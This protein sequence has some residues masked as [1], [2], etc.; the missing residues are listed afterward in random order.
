MEV[1]IYIEDL[2][3]LPAEVDLFGLTTEVVVGGVGGIGRF[4]DLL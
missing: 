2:F 1:L 4:G 3:G